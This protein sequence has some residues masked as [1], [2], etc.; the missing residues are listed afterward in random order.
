MGAQI[1]RPFEQA[2]RPSFGFRVRDG[3]MSKTC[4]PAHSAS[5]TPPG[6]VVPGRF[7]DYISTAEQNDYRSLHTNRVAVRANQRDRAADPPPRK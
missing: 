4:V 5:C 7:S 3:R 2:V 1:S 6:P